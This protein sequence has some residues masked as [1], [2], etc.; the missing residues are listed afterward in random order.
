MNY[1]LYLLVLRQFCRYEHVRCYLIGTRYTD[2]VANAA[3]YHHQLNPIREAHDVY[4]RILT[5]TGFLHRVAAKQRRRLINNDPLRINYDAD[6][7]WFDYTPYGHSLED[8]RDL[9]YSSSSHA[10]PK[11]FQPFD[12][13]NVHYFTDDDAPYPDEYIYNGNHP[14]KDKEEHYDEIINRVI[15]DIRRSMTRVDAGEPAIIGWRICD[16]WDPWVIL[17]GRNGHEWD[18]QSHGDMSVDSKAIWRCRYLIKVMKKYLAAAWRDGS[19]GP[20]AINN[21]S[22]HFTD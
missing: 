11:Y 14:D 13:P 15:Y 4:H 21:N 20:I 3:N 16:A 5:R 10:T 6:D 7:K 8:D 1:S 9:W 22:N 12:D 18:G 2:I 17:Y 19:G